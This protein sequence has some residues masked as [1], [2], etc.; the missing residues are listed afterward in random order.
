MPNG[1][2]T[3]FGGSGFL[4]RL[5]VERL[6]AAAIPVRIATRRPQRTGGS[7]ALG[8][9]RNGSIEWVR[10]DIQDQASVAA[11]VAGA[12]GV[13]N[14]V[15]LYVERD[16]LTFRSIHVDGARTVALQ[17]K[18]AGVPVLV[19]ISGLGADPASLSPYIRSRGEGEAAVRECFERPS[20][21][22]PSVMFGVDDA[23]LNGLARLVSV[24]LV[25]PLFGDGSTRLQPVWVGDVA[26]AAARLFD[27]AID[28]APIYELGGPQVYAYR[29]LIDLIAE[30][31]GRHR[32]LPS[33]PF[34]AWRLI[35]AAGRFVPGFPVSGPQVDLM[36]KD[37]VVDPGCPSFADLKID[38]KPMESVLDVVAGRLR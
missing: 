4:G 8:A 36:R 18:N 17:A 31:L 13:V 23:F 1:P 12:R 6:S 29:D 34:E 15:S 9:R 22:R 3:V 11:A 16:D 24:F 30:R 35:A 5:I 37:N 32:L 33:L 7:E 26:A 21:L 27:G 2:V 38:P 10:A 28:R 19:H 20:I 14:A 25:I